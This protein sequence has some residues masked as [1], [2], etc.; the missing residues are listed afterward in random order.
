[1]SMTY[2]LRFAP[3]ATLAPLHY[4]EMVPAAL[5]SFLVF[6]D[7][8]NPLTWCGIAV[9]FAS[10]LYVIHRERIAHRDRLVS[11]GLTEAP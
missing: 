1:M 7:F 6:G 3:S 8:P 4:L 10:G 11:R 9:I 2:A 5:F